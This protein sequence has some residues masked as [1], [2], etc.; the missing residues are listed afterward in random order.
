MKIYLKDHYEP[1]VIENATKVEFAMVITKDCAIVQTEKRILIYVNDKLTSDFGWHPDD[2][3]K[4][5]EE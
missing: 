3:I 1:M 4:I 2:I 5:E